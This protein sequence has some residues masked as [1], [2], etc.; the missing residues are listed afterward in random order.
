[1]DK[2]LKTVLGGFVL[3]AIFVLQMCT[4]QVRFTEIAVLKTA[5]RFDEQDIKT[6]P[7][8]Y[9]K[10][11]WPFQDVRITDKRIRILKDT[12][13]ETRT[14]D[15]QNVMVTTY[16]CWKIDEH[17]PYRFHIASRTID[18]A[19]DKLR[20]KVQSEKKAIV[21]KYNLDEFVNTDPDKFR[22]EAI[23]TEL[24]DRLAAVARAEYGIEVVEVGIRKLSFPA[25][26]SEKV[27]DR[28]KQDQEQKIA[29]FRSIGEAKAQA[30]RAEASAISES[31]MAVTNRLASE[32]EASAQE[33]VGKY[34]KVFAANV[35]LRLFL[36]Q[37]E[38][39]RDV[40]RTRTTLVVDSL[41]APFGLVDINRVEGIFDWLAPEPVSQPQPGDSGHPGGAP[42]S[43]QR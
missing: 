17:N 27:F 12:Y 31:I 23:E 1:M 26:V 5:G 3:A 2:K 24:R 15:K 29:E 37:L 25:T 14:A 33:E 22:F 16:V 11:P 35:E 40:L 8:L 28:M 39:S 41:V 38:A 4:Y 32:I 18:G 6:E 20:S 10:W 30:I 13:A 43:P 36:D 7:G 19:E 9:W 34:Y 21:A 42:A